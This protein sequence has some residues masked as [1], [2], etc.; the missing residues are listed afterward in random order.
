MSLRL[1]S[2]FCFVFFFECFFLECFFLT[3]CFL[4]LWVVVLSLSLCLFCSFL[5][6][7]VSDYG[8]VKAW[9][10]DTRGNLIFKGTARNFNP[11]VSLS[12]FFHIGC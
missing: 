1:L 7:I 5:K 4:S 12:V 8:L 3:L 2:F 10:A 9:K 11:E 6:A